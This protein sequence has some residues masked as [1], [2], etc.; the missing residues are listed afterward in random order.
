MSRFSRLIYSNISISFH[1]IG[2]GKKVLKS[3]GVLRLASCPGS[4][5]SQIS[6]Q[7][8]P[9]PRVSHTFSHLQYFSY[10]NPG[11]CGP[12]GRGSPAAACRNP[13]TCRL[14][15]Q[16]GRGETSRCTKGKV[17]KRSSEITVQGSS[18]LVG[19]HATSIPVI[20]YIQSAKTSL[21]SGPLGPPPW[22]EGATWAP[23]WVLRDRAEKC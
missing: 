22:G 19:S 18:C 15:K 9:D 20:A 12:R 6:L 2:Q 4:R 11:C 10:P 3:K 1:L 8:P 14:Y 23:P 7:I 21:K 13:P 16:R 5:G 17:D